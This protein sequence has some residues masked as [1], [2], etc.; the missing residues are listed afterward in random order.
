MDKLKESKKKFHILSEKAF[1]ACPNCL[2]RVYGIS[3]AQA[4]AMLKEHQRS[5]LCKQIASAL[6]QDRNA[7]KDSRPAS[8]EPK[9]SETA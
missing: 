8:V 5:K 1:I 7:R 9:N 3:K 4:E 2:Q 6:K